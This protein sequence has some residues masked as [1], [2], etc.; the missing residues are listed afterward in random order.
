MTDEISEF[1]ELHGSPLERWNALKA[2][3]QQHGLT[4]FSEVTEDFLAVLWCLDQYR[5]A[6]VPPRD[7]GKPD[8]SPAQRLDG[9]YRMK[10]GWFAGLISQL[11]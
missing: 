11:T 10:G 6:S 5:I 7:L 3:V 1:E 2:R 4:R 8:D 9:A